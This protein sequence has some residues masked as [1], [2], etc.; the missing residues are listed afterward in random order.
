MHVALTIFTLFDTG[1]LG[2]CLCHSVDLAGKRDL[3]HS[4]EY[5]HQ[6][7]MLQFLTC[8]NNVIVLLEKN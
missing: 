7:W 6:Y 4:Y 8:H 2:N 3:I 5:I 1:T